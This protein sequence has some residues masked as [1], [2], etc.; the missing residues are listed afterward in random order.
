MPKV[1]IVENYTFQYT[2]MFQEKGWEVIDKLTEADL[3]Q[4]TGGEDVSP[5]LYGQ[6]PHPRTS[7]SLQRDLREKIIFERA[8]ALFIPMAGI[9]R[10][11]QFLNVMCGGSL[12]Q[13]VEGH[14]QPHMAYDHIHKVEIKVTSTHH[15]MMIPPNNKNLYCTLLTA[16]EN[17]IKQKGFSLRCKNKEK[18]IISVFNKVDIEA[19]FYWDSQILCFQP[20]PEF[21]KQEQLSTLYFEYLSWLI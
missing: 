18:D 17:K 7:S 20:H 10:G 8:K 9:C 3:I 2:R 13:H 16:N 12:W 11:A 1:F 21:C 15:Q 4:F 6:Y 5:S 19:I 14:G